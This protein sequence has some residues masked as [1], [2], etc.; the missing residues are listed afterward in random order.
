MNSPQ[1][2]KSY[3]RKRENSFEDV[4]CHKIS[5]PGFIKTPEENMQ[6]YLSEVAAAEKAL[7]NHYNL[8]YNKLLNGHKLAICLAKEFIPGFL[9]EDYALG[10]PQEIDELDQLALCIC[11][12]IVQLEHDGEKISIENILTEV[13]KRWNYSSSV[14]SLRSRYYEYMKSKT[15]TILFD[16]IKDHKQVMLDTLEDILNR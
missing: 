8:E 3:V 4:T 16:S 11:V 6:K 15:C 7:Y 14:S 12:R 9:A 5:R 1:S 13:K 2:K 10:R